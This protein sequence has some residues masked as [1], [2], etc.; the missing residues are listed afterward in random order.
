[1]KFNQRKKSFLLPDGATSLTIHD[2]CLGANQVRL[3]YV[4]KV[5]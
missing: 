1:M 5:Q 2:L 3:K 4:P